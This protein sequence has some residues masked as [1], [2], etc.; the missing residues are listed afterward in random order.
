MWFI[1]CPDINSFNCF[2]FD[3]FNCTFYFATFLN[4][5]EI[6][7]SNYSHAKNDLG[8]VLHVYDNKF[9][10]SGFVFHLKTHC[11]ALINGVLL[12]KAFDMV[13]H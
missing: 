9:Y 11:K 7:P 8:T 12:V 2:H 5:K 3:K 6:S 13:D 4:T 10:T 1:K